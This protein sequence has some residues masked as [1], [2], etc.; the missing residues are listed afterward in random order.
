MT[1]SWPPNLLS[2]S[3]RNVLQ[4][5][6]EQSNVIDDGFLS[7]VTTF[8]KAGSGAVPEIGGDIAA[9]M[10]LEI[11]KTLDKL[12]QVVAQVLEEREVAEISATRWVTV[13]GV[14]IVLL[15]LLSALV[16]LFTE[17]TVFPS[18]F[19]SLS[20]GGLLI[21]LYSPVRERLNIA[22]D[23]SNLLLMTQGF[24]LRFV[25]ANTVE[26]LQALGQELVAAL[27]ISSGENNG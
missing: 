13:G 10:R 7:T 12:D 8:N 3:A 22:N 25:V 11:A 9:N 20:V 23:R 6:A 5:K 27:K 24:R 1:A 18:I 15:V 19:S 4:R 17:A 21:L 26:Q 2:P 16:P 14:M